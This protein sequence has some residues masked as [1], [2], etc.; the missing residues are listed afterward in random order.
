MRKTW[1]Y[2]VSNFVFCLLTLLIN[3]IALFP[4]IKSMIGEAAYAITLTD[5]KMLLTT[6]I[7]LV[8]GS[9]MYW[10]AFILSKKYPVAGVVLCIIIA[11]IM[12]L[13][14]GISMIKNTPLIYGISAQH[15]GAAS[16]YIKLCGF[17]LPLLQGAF[18]LCGIAA[19]LKKSI[20]YQLIC[21]A[22]FVL[23]SAVFMLLTVNVL[24]IGALGVNLARIPAALGTLAIAA[25]LQLKNKINKSSEL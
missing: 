23:V 25:I 6:L 9:L 16:V 12:A 15:I 5:Q 18:A 11:V 10:G 3:R 24:G 7:V 8:I 17:W 21:F 1:V 22:G 20:I 4:Y 2:A 13:T 19:E 14:G